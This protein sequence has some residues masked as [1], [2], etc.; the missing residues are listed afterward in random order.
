[1]GSLD[2]YQPAR[3]MG[4][5]FAG[6]VDGNVSDAMTALSVLGYSSAEVAPVLKKAGCERNDRRGDNK[7]QCS[8]TW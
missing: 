4:G 2:D 1:M 3:S 5:G 6:G 8:S 7:K